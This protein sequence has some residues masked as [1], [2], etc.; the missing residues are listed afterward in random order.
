[1]KNLGPRLSHDFPRA[2]YRCAITPA[3]ERACLAQA[4]PADGA[5]H[6]LRWRARHGPS[7]AAKRAVLGPSDVR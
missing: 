4:L 5:P 1:M 3:S 2:Q 6:G 7:A